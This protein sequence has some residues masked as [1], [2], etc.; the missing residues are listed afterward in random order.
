MQAEMTERRKSRASG[1]QE[2]RKLPV[3]LRVVPRTVM[4]AA[5]QSVSNMRPNLLRY[6]EL[7]PALALLTGAAIIA[8]VC[9]IYLNQV[10]TV[11]NANYTLQALQQTHTKLLREEQDLQLQIGRAQSLPN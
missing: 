7:H 11:S 10:T 1:A 9:V 8:L 2:R 4:S 5:E 6:I 3:D